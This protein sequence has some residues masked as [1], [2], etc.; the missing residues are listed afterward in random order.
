MTD[1]AAVNRIMDDRPDFTLLSLVPVAL[2]YWR[3]RLRLELLAMRP[4]SPLEAFA[5]RA[6]RDASPH[7]RD[8]RRLLGLDE[9]TFAGVVTSVM[10]NGWAVGKPGDVLLLTQQG[11]EVLEAGSREQAETRV[12]SVEYDGLL[13]TPTLLNLPIEPQ[14]RKSLGLRELPALPGTA[15]DLIE[16]QRSFDDLQNLVRRSGDGRDQ[17][18]EL[19]AV[20]GI[21]RRERL[22]REATL[23]IMRSEAG[24]MQSAPVVDGLVSDEHEQRLATPELSRKMRIASELRRGRQRAKILP[25]PLR[26]RFDVSSDADAY[27]LR[28]AA[29]KSREAGDANAS[30]LSEKAQFATRALAVRTVP[31]HEHVQLLNTALGSARTRL[32]IITPAFASA[33]I[34]REL[35]TQLESC[36]GRDVIVQLIHEPEYP[37]PASLA[38]AAK[39]WS[40]LRVGATRGLGRSILV[41]D[42]DLAVLTLFPILASTGLERKFRDERGWLVQRPENVRFVLAEVDDILERVASSAPPGQ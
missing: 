16:L 3:L 14:Q 5:M 13:R 4:I 17:G 12:V 34:D 23:A 19:I 20:K 37:L 32:V 27:A 35:L 1:I 36:L 2:P 7:L 40:S 42:D 31:P 11:D 24:H 25:E 38:T 26:N 6:C 10:A 22:Y 9:R 39:A 33:S 21:L 28:R 30:E 41:R 18:V 15:P 29:R 8:I